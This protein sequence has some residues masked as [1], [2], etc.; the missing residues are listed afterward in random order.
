MKKQIPFP[1]IYELS[2]QKKEIYVSIEL[3]RDYIISVENK[4]INYDQ[5]KGTIVNRNKNMLRKYEWVFA[6]VSKYLK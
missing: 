3:D 6:Q 4:R 2:Y 5:E 1:Y